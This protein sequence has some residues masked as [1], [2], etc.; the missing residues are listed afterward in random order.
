MTYDIQSIFLLIN[1]YQICSL[2][3]P[4]NIY[5]SIKSIKSAPRQLNQT[6]LGLVLLSS[7]H[8]IHQLNK[9]N[10]PITPRV[11]VRMITPFCPINLPFSMERLLCDLWCNIS[12]LDERLL[13]SIVL[14]L[15]SLSKR[16]LILSVIGEKLQG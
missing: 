10:P 16:N 2:L 7:P 1:R 15:Q 8:H 6:P 4:C 3:M 12:Q 9:H 13:L 14:L 11:A 5:Q